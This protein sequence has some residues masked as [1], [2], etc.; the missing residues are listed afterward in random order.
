[1]S[2]LVFFMVWLFY[3]SWSTVEA[4]LVVNQS[5]DPDDVLTRKQLYAF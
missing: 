1:M 4:Y 5:S 3:T 2:R